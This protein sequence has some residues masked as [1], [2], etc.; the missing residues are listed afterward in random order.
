M[1]QRLFLVVLATRTLGLFPELDGRPVVYNCWIM[2]RQ[3]L[4]T[5]YN[6]CSM[7]GDKH[8]H[9]AWISISAAV[10]KKTAPITQKSGC[11]RHSARMP[12]TAGSC[13]TPALQRRN[14]ERITIMNGWWLYRTYALDHR[15]TWQMCQQ[16]R[17]W[18]TVRAGSEDLVQGG[19]SIHAWWVR[20]RDNT[21]KFDLYLC[22]HHVSRKDINKGD[23]L[24]SPWLKFATK[25]WNIVNTRQLYIRSIA[26]DHHRSQWCHRPDC[27]VC[28][29]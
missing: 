22:I 17:Q 20:G 11:R 13:R 5:L 9:I 15:R 24:T 29:F 27:R 16:I 21:I 28:F 18:R 14:W 26:W 23:A 19:C 3:K 2:R 4:H 10:P 6:G 7:A 12:P 25:Q 8:T 1:H